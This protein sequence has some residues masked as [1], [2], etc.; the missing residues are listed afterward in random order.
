MREKHSNTNSLLKQ[1]IYNDSNELSVKTAELIAGII[2]DKPDALLCFP[3]GETSVGTFKHLIELN[4]N[5]Q[6]SFR[7]CKI[8]GLDEW[9]HLG[10]MKNENCFSFLRK[11]LFDHID[12]SDENLCFFDGE[13]ADLKYECQKT[14]EF[15]KENG[16]ID[17]ILLGAGMNGH[18]GLNEP[19]TS[20]DLYS[21][22]VDLDDTTRIVGQKYFSGN[23]NLSSGVTLGI[24]YIMEAG[25]VILQIS[26]SRKAEVARRLVDSEVSTGFPATVIKSHLNSFLL[27]D[28]EAARL[29]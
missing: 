26:G 3:A 2:N 1:I 9:A 17:M 27:L 28:K 8:V 11:H 13:S 19:G 18:L 22:I 12:Y 20:F 23:V 14:D 25:T 15:I 6:I 21:H 7:R 4:K 29:F 10:M 16:P 24:K 5:G